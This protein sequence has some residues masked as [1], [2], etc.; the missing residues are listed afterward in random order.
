MSDSPF[1]GSRKVAS[2][3]HQ[4]LIT[5][6]DG[7]SFCLSSRTGDIQRGEPQ[8]LF[9][10]DTRLVSYWRLL[11]NSKPIELLACG[12]EEPFSAVFLGRSYPPEGQ[13][14]S[15]LVVFRHRHVGNGM[16]EVI[17]IENHGLEPRRALL[18][19]SCD[20]DFADLFEVKESRVRS[21]GHHRYETS[22]K[23]M[24]FTLL[25]E[26]E[27]QVQIH[28]TDDVEVSRD[29]ATWDSVIEPGGSFETCIE[30]K[31]QLDRKSVAPVFC[32]G[33]DPSGS[34]PNQRLVRWKANLPKM[35][36]D[37]PRFDSCLER[38]RED[39]G[40]LRIFDPEHPDV[41]ILAAGA[42]WFMT[43]FGRDSLITA[44]MALPAERNLGRGVLE[45]LA[46]FQGSEVNHR[47]EEQP[48]KILHEMRFGDA[49][50]ISLGGGETYYG[51]IDST[52]LFVM[53][54]GELHR[55]DPQDETV[56]RLAPNIDAALTWIEEYGDRDGD[57]Y[58][59][60]ERSN[61]SSLAN[62]GWKDS[63]DAIRS[64]NGRLA[65]PPIALCEV[66]GYVYAAYRAAQYLAADRNETATAERYRKRADDLWERFNRDFWI[67]DEGFYALALDG[68][69]NPVDGIASNV[70]HCLWTGIV[71]PR[72]A[73]SVADRLLSEEFFTGW[74]LR[75]LSSAMAAYNPV[76]YHN[77][78]VWP[79]DTAIVAAG[80]KRY[81]FGRHAERLI[82][83][84]IDAA[85]AN[86]FRLPELFAGFP[87]TRMP[88]VASYPTSC[89]PQAWAAASPLLWLRT[90]LGF[91]PDLSNQQVWVDPGLPR[92]INEF[93]LEGIRLHD[94]QVS[95]HISGA[96]VSFEGLEG[97]KVLRHAHPF[98]D[99][100]R[101]RE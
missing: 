65:E 83:A 86:D 96:D 76:S 87:R 66:Q 43:V 67:E 71:D 6:L 32:C 20:V 98:A 2:L 10:L 37:D 17:S 72:R 19:L 99:F 79:H 62:Q 8:G 55:W 38:S 51:S 69:K 13:A 52:P 12:N 56:E 22:K 1:D 50:G 64:A 9:V 92:G 36:T 7:Q 53:L 46:R 31:L 85:I 77:G 40:S 88:F 74:G 48:G 24:C 27:K 101:G 44:W 28:F 91:Q 30:V 93:S 61:E 25:G 35:K 3:A 80:L 63:W 60:Y 70:G 45:I 54:A 42:P 75:T 5:V 26:V 97:L 58:V 33:V 4:G 14:D 90:M 89:S 15:D 100:P 84:Q 21:R 94:R 49:T 18:Q 57:G 11:L 95:I 23:E 68:N 29:T 59:E 34:V 78:S 41:P 39:I 47:T 82:R 16:R 81:G 73:E